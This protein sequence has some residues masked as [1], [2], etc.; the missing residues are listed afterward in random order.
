MSSLVDTIAAIVR[1]E[2]AQ[3]R[4]TELGVVTEVHPHRA[5]GDEDNYG[6][7][8]RLKGSG[9]DLPRVPVATGHIGTVAIPNVGDLVLV[10]FDRGDVHQ[11]VIVGRVYNDEDRPPPSTTDEVVFRL[12]LAEADD[13]SVLGSVRNHQDASP[14]RQVEIELAPTVKVRVVDRAIVATA[15][16]TE[17]HLEQ[18][19]GGGGKVTVKAGGSTIEMDEDGDVSVTAVGSMTITVGNDLSITAGGD[20]DIVAGNALSMTAGTNAKVV[21]GVKA[22]LE[23]GANVTARGA[24][25]TV[26]GITSFGP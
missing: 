10:S 18:P 26:N 16:Q 6:C 12:P 5:A 11:P 2:L 25:V 20:V 19:G 4:L 21:A 17:M 15:G 9:L 13:R 3:L 1:R 24:T 7:D 14:A 23:G 8:V 22:S